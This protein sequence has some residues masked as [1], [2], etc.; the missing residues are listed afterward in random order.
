MD[1][2]CTAP[3]PEPPLFAVVRGARVRCG[4]PCG[5]AADEEG[6]LHRVQ[7]QLLVSVVM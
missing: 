2:P 5:L 4:V 3:P 6:H 1:I 7:N